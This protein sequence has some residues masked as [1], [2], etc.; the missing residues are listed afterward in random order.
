MAEHNMTTLQKIWWP[1]QFL[2]GIYPASGC[3]KGG[4]NPGSKWSPIILTFRPGDTISW[5]SGT[6]VL[7]FA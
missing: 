6:V 5:K 7:E 3:R 1:G 4:I 2:A